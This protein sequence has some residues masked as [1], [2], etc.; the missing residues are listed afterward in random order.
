VKRRF[1]SNKA[2]LLANIGQL[3]TLRSLSGRAGPRRG[4]DLQEL[5]I[6]EDGAVLC[7]AGKI[8][9]VGKTKQ[10]LRD[11]WIKRNRKKVVEIDCERKVVL[12]G[13]V[14][15]HTHPAFVTPRLIDFE[16]RIGGATYEEIAEAGGGIRSS[17]E[18]VRK[19]GKR[20][21]AAS[22]L[23]GLKELS[24]FGTTTVEAKSGYGLSLEA[25]LRSLE[26]IRDASRQWPGTVIPTL[27][28]AHTIPREFR[29]CREEYVEQVC[30]EMIPQAARRK[31]AKFVDVFC[32]RGAFTQ[33]ETLKIA[34]A[35]QANG[36]QFRA[37][38]SQLS[39]T[40]L[41]RLL[42]LHPLSLDHLDEVNDHDI[43]LLAR[44]GTVAVLVPGANYFLGLEDYPA[45]RKFIAAGVAVALA[46][47]YNP[48]S[49][50]VVSM[51][52]VL[53]LGCTQMKMTP[54]ESIAAATLNGAWSLGIA[55][56][57]GSIETG[58]DA[59]LA[60][61]E[62]SDYRELAYW[63]GANHCAFSIVN[64]ELQERDKRS[65]AAVV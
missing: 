58:K 42:S 57:K 59:D 40:P 56:R 49:S 17:V 8:I 34:A 4:S 3:I 43:K 36:L 2:I 55:G 24:Q 26:A 39:R 1:P 32:D 33:E 45:A 52:F 13:F 64:G 10:A 61:V 18:S 25:E 37:H 60:V 46:T 9:A 14:D 38:V 50:P 7:A 48:G 27:L 20:E 12:P 44:S 6:I 22:V 41:E 28:G 31:L 19:A 30:R 35:G 29:D 23:D 21:L 63:V 47:D 51:P 54:A 5:G 62:A 11:S 15:S 65:K 53:S 16:K